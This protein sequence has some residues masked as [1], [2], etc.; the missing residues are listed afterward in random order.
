MPQSAARI[1]FQVSV[2]AIMLFQVA[3]L[4]ARS[5]LESFL[6][7]DGM[8]SAVASD[9]SNLIILPILAVL[10]FPYLRR[11]LNELSELLRPSSLT[12]QLIFLSLSLGLTLRIVRWSVL[13]LLLWLG[14]LVNEDPNAIVGPL[15][16]FD[17]P[18]MPFLLTSLASMAVLVPLMEEVI[19]RGF[20]FHALL[21]RGLGVSIIVS[22]LLFAALHT[23]G[24]YMSAFAIGV[25]LAVQTLN[26]RSL[27]GPIIAHAAYNAAA[28]FDWDCFR[29][30]W[31]PP[32]SDPQLA[33]V[34]AVAAPLTILSICLAVFLVTRKAAG[35]PEA[36][37][38]M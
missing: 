34:A 11:C 14:I 16:G 22:A 23:P 1:P 8:D 15:I 27:W 29:I 3:A 6:T 30:V 32:A 21:P 36:P 25:M 12:L 24:T 10:M 19:H 9:L 18:P 7:D 33:K 17:C 13:T 20:I 38:R 37:R 2:L 4:F 5:M 28:V 35:V 31:N 26:Y